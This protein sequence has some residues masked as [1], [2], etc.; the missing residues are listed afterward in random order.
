MV[1]YIH[2][3]DF[4]LISN[5]QN[6]ILF[7]IQEYTI[8]FFIMLSHLLCNIV[9]ITQLSSSLTVIPLHINSLFK[10]YKTSYV[11]YNR[12]HF[13]KTLWLFFT[14]VLCFEFCFRN[15]S[16]HFCFATDVSMEYNF[17]PIFTQNFFPSFFL[18][19]TFIFAPRYVSI[20]L[21]FLY[22]S[23]ACYAGSGLYSYKVYIEQEVEYKV[24]QPKS[25][26]EIRKVVF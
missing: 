6:H 2:N 23:F 18:Y 16:S 3:L 26:V 14:S 1:K 10:I 15:S 22:A 13:L 21:R 19:F 5:V 9:N 7:F 8:F 17:P 25:F 4:K 24:K 20:S 11:K 12:K